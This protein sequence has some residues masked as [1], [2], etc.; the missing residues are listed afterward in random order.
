MLN[1]SSKDLPNSE[2]IQTVKAHS[3]LSQALVALVAVGV[4]YFVSQIMSGSIVYIYPAVQHWS[5]VQTN[6]WLTN[7]VFA[8]FFYILIAETLTVV[9][10]LG[11]LKFFKWSRQTIGFVKPQLSH[12]GLGV[13]AV[14]PY[15]VVYLAIVAAVSYIYPSLNTGQKQEI[16]FDHTKGVLELVLVFISLVVLPPLVEEIMMRGFLYTGLRKAFPKIISALLVSGLFG[17]AHLAEG[18]NAGPLWIGAL[19]TFALSLVLVYLREKTG[20][21]WAGITLHAVKNG[22]AFVYIFLLSI[23]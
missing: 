13:L 15:F 2:P 10:L 4:I 6:D 20:N 16:G 5:S 21:L 3:G 7:S 12:I 23:R 11:M 22:T 19:D 17:I 1:D 8:Q 9:A 14:V 18:G